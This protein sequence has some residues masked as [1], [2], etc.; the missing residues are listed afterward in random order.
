MP[1]FSFSVLFF[2]FLLPPVPLL[3]SFLPLDHSLASSSLLLLLLSLSRFLL[4]GLKP[5]S[6]FLLHRQLLLHLV[7][8]LLHSRPVDSHTCQDYPLVPLGY[9]PVLSFALHVSFLHLFLRFFFFLH[10]LFPMLPSLLLLPLSRRRW[11]LYVLLVSLLLLPLINLPPPPAPAPSGQR[12]GTCCRT[13]NSKTTIVEAK[14]ITKELL[15]AGLGMV[16]PPPSDFC[17]GAGSCWGTWALHAPSEAGRR[18]WKDIP[19]FAVLCVCEVDG[20]KDEKGIM[21]LLLNFS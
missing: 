10:L 7:C 20:V 2:L 19:H 3:L 15:A 13:R 8:L 1:F 17:R 16:R 18:R 9:V 12:R 11:W 14:T 5:D 6:F 21:R 4:R